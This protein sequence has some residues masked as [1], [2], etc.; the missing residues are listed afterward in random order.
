VS[1]AEPV[2]KAIEL[3]THRILLQVFDEG[4]ITTSKG[5]TLDCKQAIFIMTSNVGAAEIAKLG[6][7]LR[8]PESH[9]P[10]KDDPPTSTS[11]QYSLIS[12][13]EHLIHCVE[14]ALKEA[15]KRDEFIGR[16][17]FRL[18]RL[19]TCDMMAL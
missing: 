8:N 11:T 9:Q 15:F 7:E 10:T 17:A 1:F 6:A 18:L 4:R 19:D 14:P 16:S 12:A 13:E 3:P 2:S 5:K